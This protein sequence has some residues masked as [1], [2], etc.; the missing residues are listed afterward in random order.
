MNNPP[1]IASIRF[2]LPANSACPRLAA[3]TENLVRETRRGPRWLRA[4]VEARL[5]TSA[6]VADF[7]SLLLHLN[8][9]RCRALL[10]SAIRAEWLAR[11][12]QEG[13]EAA[14]II[15]SVGPPDLP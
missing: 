14:D 13:L 6:A 15:F 10:T 5:H 1:A 11:C 2:E 7:D 9:P 3:L 12:E 4:R 8:D